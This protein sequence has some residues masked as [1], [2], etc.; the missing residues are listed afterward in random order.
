MSSGAYRITNPTGLYFITATI[1]DWVDIFT[2]QSYRD[3]IIEN[4]NFYHQQRGLRTYGYVIMPN[5]CHFILQQP[6]GNLSF[7][8]RDFKKMT[9]RTIA[10]MLQ[11]E[12]ESRREWLLHRLKWNAGRNTNTANHQVWIHSSHAEEI[13]S[14]KFFVQ[15]LNYIHLNPVRAGLVELPEHWIYSSAYDLSFPNPKVPVYSWM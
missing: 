15:K 13:W 14:Y 2:R 1:V 8:I 10:D 6:E 11:S 9:A 12:P 7:A 5:H 3:V 4:L